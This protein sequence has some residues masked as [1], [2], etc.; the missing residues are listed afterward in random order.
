VGS[1]YKSN[2]KNDC[3]LDDG[4]HQHGMKNEIY[5]HNLAAR[6]DNKKLNGDHVIL[7]EPICARYQSLTQF[8]ILWPTQQHNLDR[9]HMGC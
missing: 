4:G 5:V 2:C 3:A 9:N 7:F 6:P 8:E 1:D